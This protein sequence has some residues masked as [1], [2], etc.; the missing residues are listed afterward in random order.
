MN[1]VEAFNMI[2][3]SWNIITDALLLG[4]DNKS[5]HAAAGKYKTVIIKNHIQWNNKNS[6][7]WNKYSNE[8]R[9]QRS[10]ARFEVFLQVHVNKFKHKIQSPFILNHIVQPLLESTLHFTWKV[11]EEKISLLNNINMFQLTKD[12][13]FSQSCAGN[14]FIF[15]F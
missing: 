9:W 10:L 4:Y 7:W 14:S 5:S 8:L 11:Q 2:W 3:D 1:I 12:R 15:N 6:F 13:Y